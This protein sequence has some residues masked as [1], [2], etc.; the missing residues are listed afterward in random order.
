MGGGG[1]AGAD[2]EDWKGCREDKLEPV[3][4]CLLSEAGGAPA[5]RSLGLQRKP[6]CG[7][8][9]RLQLL[10]NAGPNRAAGAIR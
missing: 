6:E 8:V 2:T 1:G 3:S 4:V 10:K 5:S 9:K 7:S